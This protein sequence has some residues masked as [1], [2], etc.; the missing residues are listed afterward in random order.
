MFYD[1]FHLKHKALGAELG[2]VA[3]GGGG[4]EAL[5]Q[6]GIFGQASELCG[7]CA[8][9]TSGEEQALVL[10]TDS[11]GNA[12]HSAGDDGFTG[13]HRFQHYNG[14]YLVAAWQCENIARP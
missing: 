5:P 9:V 8:E 12:A 11:L 2:G 4:S 7:E 6:F 3:L 1:R 14:Q 13:R 10:V